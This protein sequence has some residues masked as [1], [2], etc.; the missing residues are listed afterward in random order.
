VLRVD[1]EQNVLAAALAA[2]IPLP[3]SCRAGRCA[4]CKA[5]LIAGRIAYPDD[6]IPPGIVA[7]EAA[8]GDVLLCQARP[9]SDLTIMART[10]AA[11]FAGSGVVVAGVA[12]IS[13][14]G[15][16]VTLRFPGAMPAMR[17][18]Q[19][20]DVE[21]AAGERERVPVVAVSADGADVELIELA[22]E[23]LVRA[24]GPFDAPR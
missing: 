4:S 11:Q 20:L 7:A 14:G 8:G 3:H 24:S 19:F 5:R 17:P 18:G 13:T 22:P 15:R 10:T 2:G 1:A 6:Q 9:R 12:P 21:N 23:S 16:R